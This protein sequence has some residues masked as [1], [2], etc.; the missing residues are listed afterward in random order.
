MNYIQ[1]I[2]NESECLLV[3]KNSKFLAFSKSVSSRESID[4]WIKHY[5]ELHP[6][7]NHVVYAFILGQRSEMQ[8]CS[9]DGEP[10][11]SSGVPVLNQ[12]KSKEITNTLIAVVRYFGGKKLGVSGLIKAYGNAAKQVLELSDIKVIKLKKNLCIKTQINYAHLGYELV[13]QYQGTVISQKINDKS[14]IKA[15]FELETA[16]QLLDKYIK[17]VEIDE[18]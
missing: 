16:Q 10:K 15:E 17:F 11:N 5:R 6:K 2:L 12:M 1:T 18:S 4:E 3:E 13:H 9:D 14:I 7:A 8:F